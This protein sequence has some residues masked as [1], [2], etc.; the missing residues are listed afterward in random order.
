VLERVEKTQT[1]IIVRVSGVTVPRC[2]TC[3]SGQVSYHSQYQREI[4]DLPWQGQPVRLHLRV[5]RFRCRNRQCRQQVFA[6]RLPGV[7]APRARE[8]DRRQDVVCQ[9]GYA[10]G[11][12]AGARLLKGLGMMSSDDTVLRRVKA[13]VRRR[14]ESKVRVLGVD[15]WAWRK[16]LK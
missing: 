3:S 7:V 1:E 13:R 5:R 11:G 8:T 2:P 4:Q 16:H 15:D 12:L 14:G 9:V 6:E 10:R